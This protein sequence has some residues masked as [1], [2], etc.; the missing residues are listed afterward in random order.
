MPTRDKGSTWTATKGTRTHVKVDRTPPPQ[1]ANLWCPRRIRLPEFRV[2]DLRSKV[3]QPEKTVVANSPEQA[4]EIALGIRGVRSGKPHHLICRAY[5][6]EA[7]KTSMV[8]L[9]RVS[10]HPQ[11]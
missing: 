9:Y 2:I 6:Q 3:I 7:G 4:S 8:R 10:A 1:T 11:N 5:W